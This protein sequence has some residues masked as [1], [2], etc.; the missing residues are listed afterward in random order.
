[1]RY[2]VRRCAVRPSLRAGWDSADWQ[3]AE[4]LEISH[5]RPEGS[6]HR[7]RTFCRLLYDRDG[8]SGIFLVHDRFVR[9]AHTEPQSAVYEDSCVEFFLQPSEKGYFNFEFSCSGALRLGYVRDPERVGTGFRD[10]FLLPAEDLCLV[11][12]GASIGRP[13]GE[14]AGRRIDWT[15]SFFIPFSIIESHSGVQPPEPGERWKANFF[16]CGDATS[17]PHWGSW[18]ALDERNFHLP[19]C[20]GEL[21]FR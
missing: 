4:T 3:P 12:V 2:A 9:C 15:L 18:T 16:K 8:I 17:H 1:M 20:F 11:R 14:E 7:P 10:F 13:A 6:G 19:R 5:Y 21:E